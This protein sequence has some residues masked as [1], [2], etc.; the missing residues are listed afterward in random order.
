MNGAKLPN[1]DDK[2]ELLVDVPDYGLERGDAGKILV[3]YDTYDLSSE[4][5]DFE[6]FFEKIDTSVILLQSQ[7]KI[8]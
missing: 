8:L 2:I 4:G 7:F 5:N 1:T 6:V 3:V